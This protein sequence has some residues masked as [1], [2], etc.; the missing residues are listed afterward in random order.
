MSRVLF[1]TCAVFC[2]ATTIFWLGCA[3]ASTGATGTGTTGTPPPPPPPPP[4]ATVQL[5]W[6][7]S[8]SSGV[9]GYNIYRAPYTNSCQ[10]F[11]MV[12]TSLQ[13]T[14]SYTDSKVQAGSA[15]CYAT[16][17]VNAAN[18]ESTFS[19]IVINVQIPAQ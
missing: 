15:Y 18:Q 12:N 6:H 1:Q 8:T 10:S 4:S 17:A 19:N 9:T 16:T 7:P 5:A 11:G 2:L 13:T 14:T 3:G